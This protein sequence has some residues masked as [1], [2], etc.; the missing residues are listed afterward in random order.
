MGGGQGDAD[1]IENKVCI[2]FP[3]MHSL[4]SIPGM[5]PS[6]K[7]SKLVFPSNGHPNEALC[8]LY[9]YRVT[10]VCL[11]IATASHQNYLRTKH[12]DVLENEAQDFMGNQNKFPSRQNVPD[13]NKISGYPLKTG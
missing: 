10:T 3:W 1:R 12:F 4:L 2:I 6:T 11:L 7:K 5:P 8:S 9:M 13:S